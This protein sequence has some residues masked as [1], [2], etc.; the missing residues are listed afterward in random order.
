MRY[1]NLS[2]RARFLRLTLGLEAFLMNLLNVEAPVSVTLPHDRIE[3]E[4]SSA[5]C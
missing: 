4:E 3:I 2:L 5:G 1:N